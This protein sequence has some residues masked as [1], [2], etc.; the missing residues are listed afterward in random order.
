MSL[1]FNHHNTPKKLRLLSRLGTKWNSSINVNMKPVINAGRIHPAK[2]QHRCVPAP[3][4][5]VPPPGLWPRT[6]LPRQPRKSPAGAGWSWGALRDPVA[7][8]QG[9][10]HSLTPSILPS[11]WVPASLTV[12]QHRLGSKTGDSPGE[13]PMGDETQPWPSWVLSRAA[14]TRMKTGKAHADL[15]EVLRD[16]G[17]SLRK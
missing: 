1:Y 17:A 6:W 5:P 15:M 9:P 11:P 10:L 16:P 12:P 7:A 8:H 2:R 4:T 13:R 14:D 3:H